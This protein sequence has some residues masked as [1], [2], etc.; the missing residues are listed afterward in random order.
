[1]KRVDEEEIY[2]FSYISI[3]ESCVQYESMMQFRL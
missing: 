3:P 2:P 1:M